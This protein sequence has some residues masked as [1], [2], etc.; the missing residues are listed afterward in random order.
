MRSTSRSCREAL[1]SLLL[2]LSFVAPQGVLAQDVS[3]KGNADSKLPPAED[4][5]VAKGAKGGELSPQSAQA[6]FSNPAAITINDATAATPYPSNITVSGLAG[7]ITKVTLTLTGLSHTFVEDVDMMVVAPNGNKFVFFS[8]VGGSSPG[9]AS[10]LNITLDDAAASQLPTNASLS[11]GTFR[12]TADTPS[13]DAFAA[14]APAHA[15]TDEAAPSS[16]ATFATQ[17]NGLTPAQANGTWSLYVTD[18]SGGDSGSVSGG[19]SLNITQAVPATTAGQLIISEFRLRGPSGANDEF[20][21][22]YNTTVSTLTTQ[23]ADASAGLA[24][25]ASDGTARCVVPNG[26]SIPAHG[27]FLCANSVAYSISGY[28]A[29]NGT[30]A[31]ANLTYTTDIPDNAGI[32]IFNNST[33]GA[34]FSTANRLDAVGS[35]SEANTT[36]KEGTGYPSIAAAAIDYSFYRNLVTGLPQDTNNNATDFIFVDINGTPTAAGQRLGAP[37]PENLSSPVNR[38]STIKFSLVDVGCPN[39]TATP[40]L[41][42]NACARHRDTTSDP[43]NN[44]SFGTLSVRRKVTNNTGATVTRL[45]FRVVDITTFAVPSGTADLRVRT[46][47]TYTA[48][49]SGGGTTSIQGLTLE[50]P[51]SQPN[52][53]GFNSSLSAGTVTLGTPLAAGASI[54]VHFLLGV[55]GTG[56]FRFFITVEALP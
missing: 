15:L 13:G 19:W 33:G 28:P 10:N 41:P 3:K 14:P 56:S 22:L 36:Y 4:A 20:I 6:I 21:E 2:C 17:F 32:A 29:G 24:V 34:S 47:T 5:V 49:L 23:S 44:S 48:N 54:N 26:T 50:T 18:D 25:A 43:A 55:Q 40:T 16:T 39:Q 51:P 53:G 8:D 52:G 11:S 9:S 31:T 1:A 12:P 27:H 46:S 37:G 45:R 35:T 42:N 30:T 38:F 7:N